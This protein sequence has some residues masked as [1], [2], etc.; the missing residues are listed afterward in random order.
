MLA[1]FV[2]SG[3]WNGYGRGQYGRTEGKDQSLDRA[4]GRRI[5]L[6]RGYRDGEVEDDHEPLD[7]GQTDPTVIELKRY[8]GDN[9]WGGR[10]WQ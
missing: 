7:L 9:E 1:T 10:F 6:S 5:Q 3:E 4:D 2:L 8:M